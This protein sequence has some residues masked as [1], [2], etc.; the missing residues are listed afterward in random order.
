MTQQGD[1]SGVARYLVLFEEDAT[2][3]G[4]RTMT[5]VAGIRAVHSGDITAQ[6]GDGMAH[7]PGG[8]LWADLGVAVVT[9]ATD[10]I[11]ALRGVLATRGPIAMI[12]PDRMVYAISTQASHPASA[13]AEEGSFT[14]GLRAVNAPASAATGAGVRVAVLDTGIDVDHP[15]FVGRE[16]VTRSFVDGEDVDDGHGHGTHVIGTACGPRRPDLGPGYGVAPAAEIYAGKVLNNAGAGTDGDILAGIAWAVQNGC[17]VVSM[18]LGAPVQPGQPHSVTFERAA[19]RAMNK[20]T[21][22]IAA[23]GNESARADG[24]IAPVGHPANC[25]SIMAVGAIDQEREVGD[26]SSGT[27]PDSGAVDVV[28]PGV[29]VRSSWP[30]PQRHNTLSGTSM[31]TPHAAGVAALTAEVHQGTAW[32][33]WARLSQSAAR[34]PLPSTDVGAGLV[35]AP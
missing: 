27:L 15:D 28:G 19:R 3:E 12:E 13:D 31:A 1:G 4:T 20:G 23:A 34:L 11:D 21:L 8:V 7:V 2:D 6:T 33:L 24:L 14:W 25:P 22:I 26:F 5:N 35:Q 17:V 16:M 9:A 30:M 32:E 18:S 29:D 10:Q